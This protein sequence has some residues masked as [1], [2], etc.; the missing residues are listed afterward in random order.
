M[1]KGVYYLEKRNYK[2]VGLAEVIKEADP[3]KEL[4]EIPFLLTERKKVKKKDGTYEYKYKWSK[5]SLLPSSYE[6]L[7]QQS[8]DEDEMEKYESLW[9]LAVRAGTEYAE[10]DKKVLQFNEFKTCNVFSQG[11]LMDF[12]QKLNTWF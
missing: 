7:F 10:V 5:V 12:L 1:K 8:I 2:K 11:G 9:K 4:Q 6:H 3:Q